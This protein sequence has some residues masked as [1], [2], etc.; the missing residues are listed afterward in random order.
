MSVSYCTSSIF[1]VLVGTIDTVELR[2]ARQPGSLSAFVTQS[3]DY[4]TEKRTVDHSHRMY[5]TVLVQATGSQLRFVAVATV[6]TV[7]RSYKEKKNKVYP[8]NVKE[9][10]VAC[11]DC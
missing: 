3:V 10:P 1:C 7:G 8:Q 2:Y 9:M 11:D 6:G 4:R 5:R